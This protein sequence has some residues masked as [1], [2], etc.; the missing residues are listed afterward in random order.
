M[1]RYITEVAD[2]NKGGKVV[3]ETENLK[4]AIIKACE[5]CIKNNLSFFYLYLE[6]KSSIFGNDVL[7][8]IFDEN[9]LKSFK[10]NGY[11]NITAETKTIKMI[12]ITPKIMRPLINGSNIVLCLFNSSDDL[13]KI[14]DLTHKVAYEIVI[15]WTKK[16]VQDWEYTWEHYLI[17]NDELECKCIDNLDNIDEKIIQVV[18]SIT[19]F[20]PRME[21]LT[22]SSEK[23][24]IKNILKEFKKSGIS[25]NRNQ[26]KAIALREGWNHEGAE[27]IAKIVDKVLK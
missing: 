4:I 11:L 18:D 9:K 8:K 14:D 7:G 21:H 10:K 24:G 5:L 15:P 13:K 27:E 19:E 25:F 12:L 26:I 17:E 1:E 20:I 6:G 3:Q 2:I 23:D 22:H 16:D